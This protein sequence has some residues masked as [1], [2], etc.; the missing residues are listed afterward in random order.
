[1]KSLSQSLVDHAARVIAP[2]RPTQAQAMAA[3]LG[4]VDDRRSALS[5]ALGCVVVAY[6]Q[7]LGGIAAFILSARLCTAL[8]ASAFGLLHIGL[9]W[10]NLDLKMKLLTSPSY[11][12]CGTQCMGWVST[13]SGLP[14]SHWLWQLMALGAFGVLHLIAAFMFLR[15]EISRLMIASGLIAGSAFAL[16]MMGSGGLTFPAVYA[17]LI[18]IL[19]AMGFGLAKLQ[20]WDFARRRTT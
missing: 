7:R 10:S 8:A 18:A 14:L 16:P 20:Q 2:L 1:M 6:R 3:E 15:S 5:F 17:M 9:P 11:T 19:V 4:H 12:A 13:V